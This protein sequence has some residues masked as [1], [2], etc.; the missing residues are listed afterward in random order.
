MSKAYRLKGGLERKC[1]ASLQKSPHARRNESG[2]IHNLSKKYF[3]NFRLV[4]ILFID[5]YAHKVCFCVSIDT[6]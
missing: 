6:M 1:V 3:L 4:P 5:Y 2:V